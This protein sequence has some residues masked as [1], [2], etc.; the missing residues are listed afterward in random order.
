MAL[1]AVASLLGGKPALAQGAGHKSVAV[2]LLMDSSGS[3]RKTDPDRL[4]VPAAK[5]LMALL[6]PADQVG[7][8]SFSDSGYPVLHLTPAGLTHKQRLFAAA[9]KVS[10][11]GAYTNL[12]A[13]LAQ[14]ELMLQN[15]APA[16]MRKIL[17]LMSDGKMDV[18]NKVRDHTLTQ[19]LSTQ[20][21]ANLKRDHVEV[22]SIAFTSASDTALLKTIA[23]RTGG[24][25][26]LA[27]NDRDLHQVFST[28]FESA[29]H[30]DMLPIHGGRFLVDGS[31]KE[32]TIVASKASNSTKIALRAPDGR[33]LSAAKAGHQV[34]WFVSEGFDM[35]TLPHPTAGSW[36]I[37]ASKGG[38]KAYVVT[39][40]GLKTNLKDHTVAPDVSTLAEAWLARGDAVIKTPPLLANTHF[41]VQDV[42][43][44]GKVSEVTLFDTGDY[45]DRVAH[46]AVFSHE[47]HLQQ[48][49]LH[50]LRIIAKSAT[51][52]RQQN[53]VFQ[54]T[55]PESKPATSPAQPA[56]APAAH[57]KPA[58]VVAAKPAA[59]PAVS[60]PK[61]MPAHSKPVAAKA[62]PAAVKSKQTAPSH[63]GK[64]GQLV[65]VV[66]AFVAVNAL[67]LVAL[68]GVAWWR[69]RRKK[70]PSAEPE[71][72]EGDPA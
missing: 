45:G 31:V 69:N 1:A 19:R 64:D 60:K 5:L 35:I 36:Q 20:L 9:D 43:P 21:L 46:D 4:R 29:K 70:G 61:A 55:A 11:K 25:F 14:G 32:V 23:T 38:D 30:P 71:E 37:L 49:G 63:S 16:G 56:P 10:S 13:A 26:Q 3:M 2:V 41:L 62:D 44:D 53:V 18:G 27:R 58:P 15:E 67:A 17:V 47:L 33:V 22:Y 34:R 59:K 66:I 8:V 57:S 7:L 72:A 54:V 65:R 52:E 40:L 68:V 39:N 50:K 48:P 6:S 24:L 42:R 51:F 12:Y 28:I